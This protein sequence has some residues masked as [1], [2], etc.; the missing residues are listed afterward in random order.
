MGSIDTDPQPHAAEAAMSRSFL[1]VAP[2]PAAACLQEMLRNDE[3]ARHVP[4]LIGPLVE[5]AP[6]LAE[7]TIRQGVAHPDL[8][9][10]LDTV[11]QLERFPLDTD[12]NHFYREVLGLAAR[13]QQYA[14]EVA[15]LVLVQAFSGKGGRTDLYGE[16]TRLLDHDLEERERQVILCAIA[17]ADPTS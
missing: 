14:E 1:D 7:E 2:E 5:R 8:K 6:Y 17:I 11:R 3:L 10:A 13:R 16:T 9:V 15:A 4:P 12:I